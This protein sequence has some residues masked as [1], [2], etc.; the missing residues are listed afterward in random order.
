MR[1][2]RI[3]EADSDLR[4]L[5]REL[6]TDVADDGEQLL[7]VYVNLDPRE[8]GIAASRSSGITS[9]LDEAARQAPDGSW[10]PVLDE[11]RAAFAAADYS[12]D[13]ASGLLVFARSGGSDVT[14]VKLPAPV[15]QE[16]AYDSQVHIRQLVETLPTERWSVLLCNRRSTRVLVG[17]RYRLEEVEH[18]QDEVDGQHDQG[19]WSQA[20]YAR[21][22]EEQ[23]DDHLRHASRV[24]FEHCRAGEF[25]CLLVAC[26]AEM[27]GE[28]E[29]FLHEDCRRR[30][31][32]WVECDVE[33]TTP[34]QVLQAATP[35][36]VQR[37]RKRMSGV[38]G[39]LR[40]NAGRG[41]RA[42][43]G[44]DDTLAALREQRV[45]TLV[46]SEGFSSPGMV[47]PRGDWL[48][49]TSGTCPV[50]GALL[51][52][53]AD[54]VEAAIEMAIRQSAHVMTVSRV[55]PLAEMAGDGTARDTEEF[56]GMQALGS[57]ASIVRFD[58]DEGARPT[59]PSSGVHVE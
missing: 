54:V 25:D 50:H 29:G 1:E 45:E 33:H 30:F 27:R 56:L 16:V 35:A 6:A 23:V 52:P 40:Q 37:D 59:G 47:C 31:A 53:C 57:I 15:E 42:A 36:I 5:A 24:L 55:D 3:V 18:F 49:A 51:Q 19:G 21:N 44:L 12:I 7:S 38:L 8:F 26:P 13:G 58:L 14:V 48:D 39:R 4:G 34:T 17:D 32:G 11:L 22:I 41:E 46:V 28:L 2:L 9:V 43:L 20:R 10:A